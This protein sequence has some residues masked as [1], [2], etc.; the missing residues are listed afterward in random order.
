MS[1]RAQC[2]PRGSGEGRWDHGGLNGSQWEVLVE[3]TEASQGGSWCLWWGLQGP[4]G[5]GMVL[6]EGVQEGP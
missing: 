5:L 4:N 2:G 1:W 3:N 6:G